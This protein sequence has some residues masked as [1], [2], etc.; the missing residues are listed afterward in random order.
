MAFSF[1][2][3]GGMLIGWLLNPLIW[4]VIILVM[5]G[6]TWGILLIRKKRK[7]IYE[8]LELVDYSEGK[9]GFNLIKCGY[10][11]KKKHLR[12]LWDTGEEQMET[13]DGEVI[14]YFSTEDFQ[15]INGKRGVICFRDPINQNFLV[16]IS[17]TKVIGMDSKGKKVSATELLAEIA[18][19]DFRDVAAQIVADADRE[20]SD[21]KERIIQFIMW[22]LIIVFSLVSIIVIA[23]MVKNGQAEASKLIAD[24]GKNC[25]EA[26]K[27]VCSEVAGV[28]SSGAP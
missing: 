21:W 13:K 20:T 22:G 27:S 6:A 12:G 26:A 14:Y 15:E 9:F 23:Q 11:G 1:G 17:K 3:I 5:L 7:L 4:L 16:P 25:L 24:A 2:G 10:F 19:A 28:A 8:C 18:P